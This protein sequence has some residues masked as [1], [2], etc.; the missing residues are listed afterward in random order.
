MVNNRQFGDFN[1]D[2]KVDIQD[3]NIL[4]QKWGNPMWNK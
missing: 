2:G 4:L 3:L 1:E